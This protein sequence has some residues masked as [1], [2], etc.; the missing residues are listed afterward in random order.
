MTSPS[1]RDVERKLDDLDDGSGEAVEDPPDYV[2]LQELKDGTCP[3]G[4]PSI[5]EMLSG[6]AETTLL[7]DIRDG[8]GS[9]D[10]E[11]DREGDR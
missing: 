6:V 1:R 8:S 10:S 3:P 11:G 2:L 5:A 7:V 9:E 4:T